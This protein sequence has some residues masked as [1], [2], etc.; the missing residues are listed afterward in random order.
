MQ[1]YKEASETCKRQNTFEQK[2][3][4]CENDI[5]WNYTIWDLDGYDVGY[6]KIQT[7]EFHFEGGS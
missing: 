2:T 5:I 3:V 6:I 7:S 1:T 4:F